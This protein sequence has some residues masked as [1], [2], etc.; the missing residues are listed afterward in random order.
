M[1]ELIEGFGRSLIPNL[2]GLPVPSASLPAAVNVEILVQL[3]GSGR[4]V[5]RHLG[6][7]ES[8]VRGWRHGRTPRIGSHALAVAARRAGTPP[9]LL[10][11]IRSGNRTLRITGYIFASSDYRHRT[12]NPG[13]EI[14]QPTMNRIIARWLNAEDD[15]RVEA[16]L[17]R[18][19]NTYYTPLDFDLIEEADWE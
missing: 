4:A 2:A 15:S 3:L 19:I 10:A 16:S 11:D 14:P 8:T 5:A 18:A 9:Q 12:V 6:I 17:Q 7:G 13:R 1:G